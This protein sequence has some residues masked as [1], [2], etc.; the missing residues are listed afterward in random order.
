MHRSLPLS[1]RL[2]W[3]PS[4]SSSTS[5]HCSEASAPPSLDRDEGVV[6]VRKIYTEC[7]AGS[8]DVTVGLSYPTLVGHILLNQIIKY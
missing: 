5:T 3:A 4:V 2:A 1:A 7:N 6:T 8:G